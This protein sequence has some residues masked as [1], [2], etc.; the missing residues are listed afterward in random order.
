MEKIEEILTSDE[1]TALPDNVR[2]LFDGGQISVGYLLT[3]NSVKI[4]K[5]KGRGYLTGVLYLA[6]HTI[7]GVGN[8]CPHST[9]EC[10]AGCLHGSGQLGM[11]DGYRATI[12]RTV[13]LHFRPDVFFGRLLLEV[14]ALKQRAEKQGM[15]LAIRLNGTSDIPWES[16][17]YRRIIQELIAQFPAV[18]FYDYTKI[19]VRALERYQAAH[20]MHGYH[21]TLSYS[22]QNWSACEEALR[23]GVNVAAVFADKLPKTYKGAHVINGDAHDLRFLDKRGVIVGLTYKRTRARGERR[24]LKTVELPT[25]VIQ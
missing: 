6:P 13:L 20:N 14:H 24:M 19:P 8:L 21:L 5:G 23:N 10:R 2:A 4:N 15:R 17:K 12:A 3:T 9:A 7:A 1:V 16:S 11:Q 22:G 18:H 25:F